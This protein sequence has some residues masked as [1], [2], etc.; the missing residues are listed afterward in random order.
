M[1]MLLSNTFYKTPLC[2]LFT[3]ALIVF[4][5]FSLN[6]Q[7]SF[8][9][10]K[11]ADGETFCVSLIPQKS[12]SAPMN[13]T[14]TAQVTIKVP[15]NSFEV[16]DLVS[17]N[18][19]ITWEY[20]SKST[21]PMEST[22]F[23]YLSFGLSSMGTKQIEYQ[24]GIEIP[25]FTFKNAKICQGS[26]ELMSNDDPFKSPN[27]RR[28]N[29]GN[30][31]TIFGAKGEA[32]VGN[33]SNKAIPCQMD[34]TLDGAASTQLET[35]PIVYPNPAINEVFVDLNWLEIATEGHFV[36]KDIN[37][38]TVGKKAV[39][40]ERGFNKVGLNVKDLSG[41]IFV[42]EFQHQEQT[43]VLERFVKQNR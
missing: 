1:N 19:D 20:N 18:S 35:S 11:L 22:Q 8:K 12:W 37:G 43:L 38:R 31:I 42:I 27:S 4:S 17:L 10:A 36:I 23:D 33:Y 5:S 34:L 9:L 3:A 21:A 41:G 15:T 40:L 39:Q 28:A 32:Y 26:I 16:E 30:S 24:E 13:I 6:G 29:V 2:H 7:V 25:L 14:S